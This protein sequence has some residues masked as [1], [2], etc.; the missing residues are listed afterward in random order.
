MVEVLLFGR[1]I[2]DEWD[3]DGV[4]N[5]R[6]WLVLLDEGRK[7]CLL[8]RCWGG[9]ERVCGSCNRRPL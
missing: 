9:W 8:L 1:C 2:A 6:R 3:W 5:G 4:E 7:G